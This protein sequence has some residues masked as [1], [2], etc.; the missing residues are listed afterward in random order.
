MVIEV[1]ARVS[2]R[3][4][5]RGCRLMFYFVSVIRKGV[6]KGVPASFFL[7][8]LPILWIKSSLLEKNKLP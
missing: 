1:R 5:E 6:C 4:E 3:C 7:E 2:A 8:R